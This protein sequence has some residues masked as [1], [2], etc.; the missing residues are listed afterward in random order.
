MLTLFLIMAL[1]FFITGAAWAIA[2]FIFLAKIA[3]FIALIYLIGKIIFDLV[4]L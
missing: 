3:A 4:F 1:F 2:V